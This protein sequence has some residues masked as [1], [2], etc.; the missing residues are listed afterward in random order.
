M[1]RKIG[2][3]L[4]TR[5]FYMYKSGLKG[6]F[7]VRTCFPDACFGNEFISISFYLQILAVRLSSVL[8]IHFEIL[9]DSA[10]N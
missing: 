10:P 2:I 8:F 4:H 7:T 9:P 5:V 3:P 6:V 1:I